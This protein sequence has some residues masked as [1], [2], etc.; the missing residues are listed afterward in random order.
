[1]ALT[2]KV[3][4][5][6]ELTESAREL[7]VRDTRELMNEL[8]AGRMITEASIIKKELEQIEKSIEDVW[9]NI[10]DIDTSLSDTI[11]DHLNFKLTALRNK[12][13]ALR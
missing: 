11:S 9:Q 4:T 7:A 13:K 3:A 10:N 5:Y 1:M 2:S 8:E 12:R 6:Q